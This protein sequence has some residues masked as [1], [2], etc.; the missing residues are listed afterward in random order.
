MNKPAFKVIKNERGSVT[1]L[2]KPVNF[3][4]VDYLYEP[5]ESNGKKSYFASAIITIPYKELFPTIKEIVAKLNEV[6]K[7]N[8]EEYSIADIFSN[9]QDAYTL[10]KPSF[11]KE[12]VQKVNQYQISL[13]SKKSKDFLLNGTPTE[14]KP[15]EKSKASSFIYALEIEL[16]PG[17]S[18]EEQENYIYALFH[19]A[20]VCGKSDSQTQEN[21]EAWDGF[22]LNVEEDTPF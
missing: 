22:D 2:V 19:R 6:R 20:F 1:V 7:A 15:V 13:N 21:D 9:E 4:F 16:V 12:D 3:Y 8:Q 14:N 10:F 18:E 17:F 5:Y 11:D